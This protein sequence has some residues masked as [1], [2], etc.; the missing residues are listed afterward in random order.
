[1]KKVLYIAIAI[2]ILA[3]ACA[4][5][6]GCGPKTK[7]LAVP[8][9]L[10]LDGKDVLKWKAVEGAESYTVVVNEQDFNVTTNSLDVFEILDAYKTYKIKVAAN[11]S[12]EGVISSDWSEELVV[13][14]EMPDWLAVEETEDGLG[15][16]LVPV[17]PSKVKGKLIVPDYVMGKPVVAVCGMRIY[18]GPDFR[19]TAITGVIFPD[20]VKKVG[21]GTFSGCSQFTR[22]RLPRYLE[23]IEDYAFEY[24]AL[25]EVE[26]PYGLKE[27]GEYAF[28]STALEEVELPY[29]LT[30]MGSGAFANTRL[31]SVSLPSTLEIMN[32]PNEAV[33]IEINP[34][35]GNPFLT[36]IEVDE[37]NKVYKSEGNCVIR[38]ADN[39]LAV[40]CRESE[41]PSYVERI[42]NFAFCE[43]DLTSLTLPEG[44]VSIGRSAFYRNGG[45]T[46]LSLPQSLESIGYC[47][48][49][50]CVGLERVDFGARFE[51]MDYDAFE[52]CVNLASITVSP[53]NERY[54]AKGNCLIRKWDNTLVLGCYTSEIPSGVE[55][56]GDGAFAGQTRLESIAFPKSVTVIGKRAFIYTGLKELKLP[57]GLKEIGDNAFE[58]CMEIVHVALPGSLESV[59][60]CAFGNM[61]E[62]TIG[63]KTIEVPAP[64]TVIVPDSVVSVGNEAFIPWTTI[65]T[66]CAERPEGW[67]Y[68][69]TPVYTESFSR[70][71]VFWGCEL[72]FDQDNLPY[73]VSVPTEDYYEKAYYKELIYAPERSGYTLAGWATERD[74]D[75][76]FLPQKKEVLFE[77]ILSGPYNYVFIIS[78][79][80]LIWY[81]KTYEMLEVLSDEHYEDA[82]NA[83]VER[84]YPVWRRQN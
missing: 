35:H 75:V 11:S 47:A 55:R 62:I 54:F 83:G 51:S 4:L 28:L 59:G 13:T 32:A 3:G 48:F 77:P 49:S 30:K 69:Q 39:M 44:L 68:E 66:S 14:Q 50:Q 21:Y 42:G 24:T 58:D 27:I 25:E 81:K 34:F 53:E 2:V 61:Q 22:V 8:D 71:I 56:I 41:I 31:K 40:G 63:W 12:A 82:R 78:T 17:D 74:G 5:L 80:K 1:M 52:L 64:M 73:L 15:W 18:G 67:Y 7:E 70:G 43:A 37:G 45:L 57:S 9:G 20:T 36:S 23:K 79:W 10:E 84:L 72:A 60:R 6:G 46:E 65:Y 38:I 26:L 16:I 29:G 76:V 33:E 19:Q